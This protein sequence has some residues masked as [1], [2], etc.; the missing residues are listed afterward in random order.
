MGNPPAVREERCEHPPNVNRA[1]GPRDAMK[2]SLIKVGVIAE[3]A[4][5]LSFME[6]EGADDR[7]V[8]MVPPPSPLVDGDDIE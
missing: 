5:S 3:E 2:E 6:I 4:G 1:T 7:S 8:A